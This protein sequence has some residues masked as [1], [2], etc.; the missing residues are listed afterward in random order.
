MPA[1]HGAGGVILNAS[2]PSSPNKSQ[3]SRF[4]YQDTFFSWRKIFFCANEVTNQLLSKKGGSHGRCTKNRCYRFIEGKFSG[5]RQPG[6]Q[7]GFQNPARNHRIGNCFAKG[8][9]RK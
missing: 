8:E 5:R 3:K 2:E 6:D 7:A 9:G 1:W 4:F